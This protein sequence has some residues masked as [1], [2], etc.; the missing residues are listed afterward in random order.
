MQQ[1]LQQPMG[2]MGSMGSMGMIG[3]IGSIG[4]M[5]Y[6][7]SIVKQCNKWCNDEKIDC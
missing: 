2:T 6:M 4:L 7:G 3:W 5:W 1:T